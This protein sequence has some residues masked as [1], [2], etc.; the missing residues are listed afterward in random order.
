MGRKAIIGVMGG[1]HSVGALAREANEVGAAVV[2][3]Q[4]ILLT[5]GFCTES[6]DIKHAAMQGAKKE[7]ALHRDR[8]ARLVGILPEGPRCWDDRL[9][10]TLF[11]KTNLDG[12]ER[13]A[14][15]GVTPDVL[16][17]FAGSCGT[18]CEVAFA[19]RAKRP[20][21]FWN[22]VQMLRE[23]YEEHTT[24]DREMDE[25]LNT[26]LTAC[27]TKL[28][29]VGGITIDTT[30]AMLRQTLEDQLR[31]ARDFIGNYTQLVNKALELAGTPKDQ[32]GFPGFRDER[33][34]KQ[35]FEEILRRIS[36]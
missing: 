13:D 21:L 19:V 14:I 3:S 16:I 4:S 18:L 15:N 11:L 17:V 1:N 12:K 33:G 23:R 26:A 2:R 36:S 30:V 6:T 5:G 34:S 28:T 24:K 9:P 8:I 27:N 31:Q 7:A 35:R 32:S 25:F 10:Y 20:V 22:A 29:S